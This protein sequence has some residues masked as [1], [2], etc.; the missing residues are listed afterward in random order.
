MAIDYFKPFRVTL[1]LAPG[2]QPHVFVSQ[3]KK[4]MEDDSSLHPMMKNTLLYLR[5]TRMNHIMLATLREIV[6]D[7]QR[8]RHFDRSAEPRGN[9]V[10]TLWSEEEKQQHATDPVKHV[11]ASFKLFEALGYEMFDS[12]VASE[13][14]IKSLEEL[15]SRQIESQLKGRE[16]Q[17]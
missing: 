14:Y 10:C 15:T 6:I 7:P 3:L 16:M 9:W 11:K 1:K 2:K 5:K 12:A 8:S 4:M 13:E 17:E